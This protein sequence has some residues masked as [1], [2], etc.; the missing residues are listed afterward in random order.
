MADGEFSQIQSRNPAEV[1]VT[2]RFK[3]NGS[4][5]ITNTQGSTIFGRG[6]SV[7]Y[8][9]TGKYTLTLTGKFGDY[10]HADVALMSSTIADGGQFRINS[11]TQSGGNTVVVIDHFGE[12]AGGS[13]QLE[14]IP[15]AAG[16]FVSFDIAFS[17]F[18]AVR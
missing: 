12:D 17:N 3:P 13:M 4:S 11:V 5:A 15:S 16:N 14:D 18:K 2:G 7:A 8:T 10:L 9:S 1:R 6:F